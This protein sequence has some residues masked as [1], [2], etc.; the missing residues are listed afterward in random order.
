[1]KL[2]KLL[3]LALGVL[4]V[5]LMLVLIVMLAGGGSTS[6]EKEDAFIADHTYLSGISVAGVD[7]SGLTYDEAAANPYIL[8]NLSRNFITLY[9]LNNSPQADFYLY[10]S[11]SVS[12]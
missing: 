4:I 11:A 5:P 3:M 7:I 12:T 8:L 6:E 9:L 2:M 10:N 1:M